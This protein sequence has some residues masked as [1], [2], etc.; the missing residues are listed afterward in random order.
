MER[1]GLAAR[2]R[3]M[4]G[5]ADLRKDFPNA[6]NMRAPKQSFLVKMGRVPKPCVN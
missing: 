1:V 4:E 6:M 2:V 5:L 3:L